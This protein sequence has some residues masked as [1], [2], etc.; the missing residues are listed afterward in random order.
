MM[1]RAGWELYGMLYGY[2]RRG[3]HRV[4][5]GLCMGWMN[6]NSVCVFVIWSTKIQINFARRG[7]IPAPAFHRNTNHVLLHPPPPCRTTPPAASRGTTSPRSSQTCTHSPRSASSS[8][9][10]TTQHSQPPTS[11]PP[12][13]PPRAQ[14]RGR[15]RR[16][17]G[18]GSTA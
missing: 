1:H 10:S 11:T 3:L 6:T 18:P 15:R 16:P 8:S 9:S 13:T 12:Q 7:P 5:H 2:S 14:G 4:M 17:P